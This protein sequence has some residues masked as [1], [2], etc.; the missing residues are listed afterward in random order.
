ME[1]GTIELSG[2]PGAF[3]QP[4]RHAITPHLPC[5][6]AVPE[7]RKMAHCWQFSAGRILAGSM[8]RKSG[9]C[10]DEG[11]SGLAFTASHPRLTNY[12]KPAQTRAS[13]SRLAYQAW[14]IPAWKN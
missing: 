6:I 2:L 5:S 3:G 13:L 8:G 12:E 9:S 10:D 14:I 4:C 7:R 11:A 1:N